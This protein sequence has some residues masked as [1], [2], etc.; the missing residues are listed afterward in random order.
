MNILNDDK[1]TRAFLGF[2]NAYK[3]GMI[4]D[5]DITDDVAAYIL[6]LNSF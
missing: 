4:D 1:M 3:D 6:I 2:K 5:N